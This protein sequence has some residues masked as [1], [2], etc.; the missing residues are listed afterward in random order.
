MA[1]ADFTIRTTNSDAIIALSQG[2]PRLFSE[3]PPAG[4]PLVGTDSLEMRF[5]SASLKG[6]INSTNPNAS[7]LTSGRITTLCSPK[8]PDS[9]NR[10][11][12]GIYC[13]A[14]QQDLISG[15]GS[16]YIL[17]LSPQ[18]ESTNAFSMFLA[19]LTT[20]IQHKSG[21]P[22]QETAPNIWVVDPASPFTIDLYWSVQAGAVLLIA[23]ITPPG[24]SL[25]Y[26]D[27]SSPLLTTV[28]E[29]LFGVTRVGGG[30]TMRVFFDTTTIKV[31]QDE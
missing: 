23:T 6:I 5:F 16:C 22:I 3:A 14:S 18:A 28:A 1:F 26:N 21:T 19:K 25:A 10:N 7:R 9:F 15:A 27:T 29:G 24:V 17:G 31:R 20:G 12:F 4:I 11:T 30:S 2:H 8:T 13:L